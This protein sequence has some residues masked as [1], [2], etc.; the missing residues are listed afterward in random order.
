MMKDE[1]SQTYQGGK[2]AVMGKGRG[3]QGGRQEATLT[4]GTRPG[5]NATDT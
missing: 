3:C 1:V 5:R 4:A 2:E